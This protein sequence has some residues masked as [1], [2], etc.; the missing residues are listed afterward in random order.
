M[1]SVEET[2]LA[3]A[4][5]DLR[6]TCTTLFQQHVD[7]WDKDSGDTQRNHIKKLLVELVEHRIMD[8][9]TAYLHLAQRPL[10][11]RQ[12]EKEENAV[13]SVD[14]VV[15]V[16]PVHNPVL[17]QKSDELCKLVTAA[18]FLQRA[19]KE[20][21]KEFEYSRSF[22]RLVYQLSRS[23]TLIYTF[24]FPIWVGKEILSAA[25]V[26]FLIK[27]TT[28]GFYMQWLR[29]ATE[30]SPHHEDEEM[31]SDQESAEQNEYVCATLVTKPSWRS[32]LW[33]LRLLS[34]VLD[35][36]TY[37]DVLT[38]TDRRITQNH[39][40]RLFQHSPAFR[41]DNIV[42]YEAQT[43]TWSFPII[44][45]IEI[46]TLVE[47]FLSYMTQPLDTSACPWSLVD[48]TTLTDY[49]PPPPPL[50]LPPLATVS[51]NA[52]PTDSQ[53]MPPMRLPEDVVQVP[54]ETRQAVQPALVDQPFLFNL[55][56][57]LTILEKY[58]ERSWEMAENRARELHAL[59]F[60]DSMSDDDEENEQQ[61]LQLLNHMDHLQEAADDRKQV[62]VVT[63]TTTTTTAATSSSSSPPVPASSPR[64]EV[65]ARL[66]RQLRHL[67]RP[68]ASAIQATPPPPSSTQPAAVSPSISE[69]ASPPSAKRVRLSAGPRGQQEKEEDDVIDLD[70]DDEEEEEEDENENEEGNREEESDEDG[71][72]F[73]EEENE[74]EDDEDEE[75]E[76]DEEDE[77]GPERA[78]HLVFRICLDRRENIVTS[79]LNAAG[80]NPGDHRLPVNVKFLHEVGGTCAARACKRAG[81]F[82]PSTPQV[83]LLGCSSSPETYGLK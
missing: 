38:E 80:N 74:D 60:D 59:K 82:P 56:K 25:D 40:V 6:A 29:V 47:H 53:T 13:V 63:M 71:E 68:V 4:W 50:P 44:N 35:Q 21:P 27:Q 42:P 45:K 37:N 70:R 33:F 81:P 20:H 64:T 78:E 65:T 66:L 51:N 24:L 2:I 5:S 15:V 14:V 18:V 62:E 12:E 52:P 67:P 34:V 49:S 10:V 73:E 1:E 77:E 83:V 69:P 79:M 76:E 7:A 57:R 55:H 48:A 43:A 46:D 26:A 16:A 54:R 9:V 41:A 11:T 23:P 8:R 19:A 30:W 22:P 17:E 28:L 3:C 39:C 58:H 31:D 72:D 36:I 61:T 75:E 32:G